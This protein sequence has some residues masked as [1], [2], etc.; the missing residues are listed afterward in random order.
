MALV[1]GVGLGA[2]AIQAAK[3]SWSLGGSDRTTAAYGIVEQPTGS[4]Y[5]VLWLGRA[6]GD[7]FPTP[8]GV[9]DGTVDA[10]TASVRYA[11][12]GS[13]GMSALDTAR[14]AMGPGYGAL[15]QT[16]REILAGQT[17]HGGALLAPFGIR[18]VVAGPTDLTPSAS[19]RLARQLDLDPIPAGGLRI[20][21][22]SKAT[23]MEAV[24]RDPGW[25]QAATRPSTLSV[26]RLLRP[27]ARA[28]LRRD[29][30]D[31]FTGQ[32][33][34]AASLIL[35]AQQFDSHWR[36]E[37]ASSAGGPTRAFGWA[38]GFVPEATARSFEVRFNGQTTRTLETGLLALL[39]MAGLWMTRRPS[40][41]R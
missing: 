35:L 40:R 31:V 24:T 8:G 1:I 19:R 17:R 7:A 11:V 18:F 38:V 3:G 22:N 25:R 14:P 23:P 6:D 41:V 29:D 32:A 10:G 30:R 33:T 2:Q 16:L 20:F 36:L 12:R 37:G 15:E 13:E 21:E 39:W 9:P 4:F 5:R 27:G 34:N 28:L 26:E